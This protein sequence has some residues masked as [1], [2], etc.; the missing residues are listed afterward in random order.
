MG[1][2]VKF[3]HSGA[4][5]ITPKI[6]HGVHKKLPMLKLEFAGLDAPQ[7]PHLPG[8]LTFLADIVEDFAEGITED[9]P[10][11]AI[12]S[13]AFALVYAHR[14]YDLIPDWIPDFGHA[15][16][17][18]IVRAVLLENEKCFAEYAEK[19]G[20]KWEKISVEA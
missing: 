2:I 3:V 17:S 1:E 19:L 18:A 9:I 12:A 4:A 15:D 14:Q 20:K 16:D 10:Y 6:L 5:R 13:A 8:Q 11:V 7:H